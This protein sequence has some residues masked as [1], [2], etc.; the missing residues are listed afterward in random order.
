MDVI[1]RGREAEIV[2]AGPGRVLRRYLDRRDVTA[3]VA[4]HRYVAG[5]GYPV[6]EVLGAERDA[7]LLELI[8]GPTLLEAWL[9][10]DVGTTSAATVLA[11]LHRE[12]HALP[13]PAGS[14]P[15]SA[16]V[17]GDLHPANVLL[18][19]AGPVVI[20]WAGARAGDPDLDVAHTAVLLGDAAVAGIGAEAGDAGSLPVDRDAVG[21][22]LTAFLAADHG[23]DPLPRLDDVVALRIGYGMSADGLRAGAALVRSRSRRRTAG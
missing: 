6:P 1:A 7:M 11:D 21:R 20:D 19:P 14:P 17:H 22:L 13:A 9:R 5:L 2:A 23:G 8:E 15:G 12:L 3:E 16:V 18:G 10:G 4:L